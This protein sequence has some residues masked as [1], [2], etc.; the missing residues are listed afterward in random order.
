MSGREPHETREPEILVVD[1]TPDS[2]QLLTKILSECGYRVRP[3][4][5]GRLALRSV[6]AKPPDLI[7]LDVKMPDMGGY[8]VC[9]CLKSAGSSSSIPVIFISGLGETADKV[10]GFAAGAVDYVTKPFEAE[11]VVARVRTQLRL[12]ELTERLEWK[13][14]ERTAALTSANEQLEREIAERLRAEEDVSRSNEILRAIIEAA[15]VGIIGLDLEGNVHS[16]WNPAAE[17]LLGW[18]SEEVMGRPLPS[19]PSESQDEFAGFMERIR[20][21]MSLNGVEVRRSRRDGTL[22]DFSVYASPLRD[23]DGHIAGK[24]AVIVDITERVESENALRKLWRAVEQSPTSIVV[25]DTEGNIEYVNPKFTQ[26]T[27][28]TRDEAVGQNPR[29]LKSGE[30]A[31]EEYKQLWDTISRGGVWHGEFHNKKKNGELYWESATVSPVLDADGTI[32]NFVAVKEDIT[33]KKQAERDLHESE[34]RYRLVFE[35]SPVSIWEED[36]S[37]VKRLFDDLRAQGVSNIEEHFSQYPEIVRECAERTQVVDVNRAALA[38]HAATSKEQLL[39]RLAD[40]FTPESFDMFERELICLWR[41]ETRMTGDG[42]VRTLV[43]DRRAVTVSFSVCPG[44]EETLSKVLVSLVD[45]TE[46]KRTEEALRSS[47]AELRTLIG[48]MT[49]VIVVGNSEGRYLKIVDSSPSLLYKPSHEL[50]GRTLH[51]VFSKEQADFFLDK[52]R[53]ALNNRE[54][55]NF[56]YNLPIRGSVFWF[57][58]TVS[59]VS[60][61]EFLMVARDITERVRLEGQLRQAQKMDAVG[62]LAGGVAHDYNNML[63]VILGHMDLAMDQ[64]VP[65]SPL[66]DDL[67]EVQSAARR[68]ADLTRQL[69][70][71]ARKQTISPKVLD[72]NETVEGMLKMLQRLIGEDVEL[73]WLPCSESWRIKID[74]S[75]IDQILANLCVNAR[76]AIAGVGRISMET[77]T[78]TIDASYCASHPDAPPGEYM[79]L[80]VSDSGCGMDKQTLE[81][82]FEPFFTTKELGKGTGLGLATVYGIVRQNGGFIDVYSEP[83]HGTTFKTYLKRHEVSA[84]GQASDDSQSGS[85]ARGDETILLVED[86]PSILNVTRLMLEKCGYS[87]LTAATVSEAI[88]L[89]SEH[90]GPLSLL[91]TDVVMPEM[92]GP[93]LLE[94]VI[95]RQ[96]HI[97][98]LYMSGYSRDVISRHGVLHEH[99]NFIQKPFSVE[100]LATKVREVLDADEMSR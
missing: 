22:A 96:P 3:S 46:R 43:G 34:E 68:S 16:Q 28:Y 49:D 76:D 82:V 25:T 87:V 24:I 84:T 56:E 32:T 35:N 33:A 70:A 80:S 92:H 64:V 31:D 95:A 73:A 9:R 88:R 8:E 74:P 81:Q 79:V 91:V 20:Q 59:P 65:S 26:V 38:L 67:K 17:R 47:E 99:T 62:R 94:E 57:N 89:A 7:M 5:S 86:E 93:D 1:D 100:S 63:S 41:G 78:A 18:T 98:C 52:I 85:I 4:T 90:S 58:A 75:Q 48:A 11:E 12:R 66:L 6:S 51:E 21:G 23:A 13:V 10:K 54:S 77:S 39:A 44:H 61:D 71:F 72:L 50:L 53:Q 69:L 30:V 55:V 42:V 36:F 29:I 37:E 45:I 19:V 15:P 60:D 14:E 40:T 27:G 97:R 83:E 2:L